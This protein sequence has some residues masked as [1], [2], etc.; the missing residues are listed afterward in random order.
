MTVVSINGF[1]IALTRQLPYN[2]IK[3]FEFYDKS[4]NGW[5]YDF[6]KDGF[7]FTSSQYRK[8]SNVILKEVFNLSDDES[9]IDTTDLDTSQ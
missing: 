3:D 6:S 2:G 5:S 4:L 9:I 8:F 1:I 7:P